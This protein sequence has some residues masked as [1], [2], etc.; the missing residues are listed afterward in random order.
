MRVVQ[1]AKITTIGASS[2]AENFTVCAR[3]KAIANTAPR[4]IVIR[5]VKRQN[6]YS[7]AA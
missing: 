5:R 3:P 4:A 2:T 7:V 6:A 1:T